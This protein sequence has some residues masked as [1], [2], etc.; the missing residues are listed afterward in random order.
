M[1]CK[2]KSLCCCSQKPK[3][4]TKTVEI[5]VANQKQVDAILNLLKEAEEECTL[6]FPFNTTVK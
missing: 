2:G 6:D 3:K 4:E 1:N 5:V